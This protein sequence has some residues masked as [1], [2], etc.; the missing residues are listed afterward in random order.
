MISGG[1]IAAGLATHD[2]TMAAPADFANGSAEIDIDINTAGRPVVAGFEVRG[3]PASDTGLFFAVI[4][5]NPGG[6]QAFVFYF[7]EPTNSNV[8]LAA[9]TIPFDV[10]AIR[11]EISWSFDQYSMTVTNRNN[12]SEVLSFNTSGSTP[13]SSGTVSL[14]ANPVAGVGAGPWSVA[15]DNFVLNGIQPPD[16]PADTNGDGMLTPADFT[17]WINAFNNNLPECD[18][19]NDGACTPTDFTAW[20]ANYNAGC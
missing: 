2:A 6:P 1:D 13:F 7:H 11:L 14:I 20:I 5:D 8:T 9:P 18:Q 16:C 4:S 15:M 17:A 10:S 19:N 3:D 12:T